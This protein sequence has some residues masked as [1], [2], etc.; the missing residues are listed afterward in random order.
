MRARIAV[1]LA[2]LLP[3]RL[4]I[5]DGMGL[6][7]PVSV[8]AAYALA[9]KMERGEVRRGRSSPHRAQ[10]DDQMAGR[11]LRAEFSTPARRP[12][13]SR[14]ARTMT[15]ARRLA[16]DVVGYALLMDED[17]VGTAVCSFR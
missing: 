15:A 3:A 4:L 2:P 1:R 10:T 12:A 6:A 13:Q 17:N 5:R 11:N 8:A 9:G 7:P 14:A 16:T